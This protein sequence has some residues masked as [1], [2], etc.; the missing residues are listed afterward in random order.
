MLLLLPSFALYV[1]CICNVSSFVTILTDFRPD[2]VGQ[3]FKTCRQLYNI[4]SK[5]H[6]SSASGGSGFACQRL[7]KV[8]QTSHTSTHTFRIGIPDAVDDTFIFLPNQNQFHRCGI[9]CRHFGFTL[10]RKGGLLLFV[11]VVMYSIF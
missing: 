1:G 4:F 7:D 10:R 11:Y 3:P 8:I 9:F 6:F 2:A 5:K